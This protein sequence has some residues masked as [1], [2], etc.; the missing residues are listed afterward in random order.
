LRDKD[1]KI[2][3]LLREGSWDQNR[4]IY[5]NKIKNTKNTTN[6]G[7][8]NNNFPDNHKNVEGENIYQVDYME[9]R[10]FLSNLN[11]FVNRENQI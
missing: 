7:G 3:N 8:L 1:L 6:E 9:P 4:N 5:P 10:G 11:T 2:N